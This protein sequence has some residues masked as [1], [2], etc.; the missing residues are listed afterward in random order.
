[1]IKY[2]LLVVDLQVFFEYYFKRFIFTNPFDFNVHLTFAD[3]FIEI[4]FKSYVQDNYFK[5]LVL[6]L[7][8]KWDLYT[9]L[10]CVTAKSQ[11]NIDH[12][13]I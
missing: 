3:V 11:K 12:F 9:V 6:D 10:Y 13:K 5:L 2:L 4:N 8:K 7:L 1:M